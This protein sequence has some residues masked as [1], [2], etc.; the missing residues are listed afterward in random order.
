M[1]WRMGYQAPLGPQGVKLKQGRA[2][3]WGSPVAHPE[4]H[5][6]SGGRP[7]AGAGACLSLHQPGSGW[8]RSH[9]LGVEEIPYRQLV[10]PKPVSASQ[11]WKQREGQEPQTYS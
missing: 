6:H 2:Q 1:A 8:S 9:R 5:L 7:E 3:R 10:K 11:A 4:E